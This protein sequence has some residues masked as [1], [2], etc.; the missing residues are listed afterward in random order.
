MQPSWE[1]LQA[2]YAVLETGSLSA[3]ARRLGVAQPTV[4]SRIDALEHTLSTVLFARTAAGLM[5]TDQ[6]RA[7]GVHAAAMAMAAEALSRTASGEPDRV[8]GTVRVSVS[9]FVGAVVLPPMLV[10]LRQAHPGLSIEVVPSN[11]ASDLGALE[12][13]IAVRMYLPNQDG[14]VARKV[15]TIDLGF[16]AHRDYIS[17]C[18]MPASLD[19][20]TDHALIGPDRSTRDL[21]LAES[22]AQGFDVRRMAIRSDSHMT[23]FAAIRAGAGIGVVQRPVGDEDPDLVSVLPMLTV[24]SMDTWIVVHRDLRQLPKIRAAYDWLYN[25]FRRYARSSGEPNAG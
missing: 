11:D 3:A 13:D 7:M 12:A 5:P 1:S 16:Y 24:A 20:L 23:Q 9:E 19:A 2:F 4:R 18:G 10:G 25:A 21:A 22:V 8:T 14:L 15:G 6:A 17:R